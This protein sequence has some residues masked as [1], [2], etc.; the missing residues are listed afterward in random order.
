[1]T[2]ALRGTPQY[3]NT[4]A[5]AG[6]SIVLTK[7]TGVMPGD[8]LIIFAGWHSGGT[9]TA[10]PTGFV[11][12][13]P[14]VSASNGTQAAWTR[15]ADGTEASTFTVTVSAVT[16]LAGVCVAYSGAAVTLDSAPSFAG[17]ITASSLP[18]ASQS[19]TTLNPGDTL[20]WFAW[21]G[22]NA[23]APNTI[24]APSGFTIEGSQSNTSTAGNNTGVVMADMLQSFAGTLTATGSQAS[25]K[26]NGAL[27]LALTPSNPLPPAV[28]M[29]QADVWTYRFYQMQNGL[30]GFTSETHLF[31]LPL[32]AVTFSTKLG[33]VGTFQATVEQ[34]DPSIQAILDGQP[35]WDLLLDRTAIYVDLNGALVWGGILQQSSYQASTQQTQLLGQD[36]WGYFANERIISWNSSYTN[37]EQLLMAADLIN[38]AQGHASSSSQSPVLGAGYVTGGNVGVGLG[39][40]AAAALAGSFSSGV[41][42]TVAWA[43]S[44]FKNIG[45]AVSDMGT[46]ANGFDWTIDVSY[47]SGVPTKTFN[48]W[49][50]RAGRTYQ[51][52]QAAGSAVVFSLP[53]FSGQDYVWAAG[54]TNPANVMFGAGSGSANSAIA[55]IA[56]NPQL[57]EEGWPILE[58]STSFTDVNDQAQ[59]DSIT[60]AYLNQVQLPIRQ[61]TIQYDV[62]SDS[63]QPL[64][65]F[66]IGDDCR[67]IIAPDPYFPQGYDSSR[68]NLGENW[69]RII[70]TDVTVEDEGK[71]YMTVVLGLPPIFPGS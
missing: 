62:G 43:E 65:S 67:L 4:G 58:D 30:T 20:V 66:A 12:L 40:Q 54:A 64:G 25:G 45:Q 16:A 27:L 68:G 29:K 32:T 42:I 19:L 6:T 7:P 38:I 37:V 63:D 52:Q 46:G 60:L 10:A 18:I 48:L 22:N 2:I 31:D 59:L 13:T 23:V 14:Q 51:K 56:A 39:T 24:T 1:V 21:V 55:S 11:A 49:Y 44:A 70:E 35:P 71:S 8:Q 33:Q 50:P 69:W 28:P 26:I 41:S 17:N 61:P 5:S 3:A 36:W 15:L 57:L 47:V 53:G 9:L 34:T